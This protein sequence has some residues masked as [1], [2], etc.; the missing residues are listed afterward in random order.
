MNWSADFDKVWE[1]GREVVRIMALFPITNLSIRT[2]ISQVSRMKRTQAAFRF[3]GSD[4]NKSKPTEGYPI[5]NHDQTWKANCGI[6]NIAGI[7]YFCPIFSDI[8]AISIGAIS[9]RTKAN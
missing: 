7:P 1:D 2:L 9:E 3:W 6:F 5:R 8:V 4:G